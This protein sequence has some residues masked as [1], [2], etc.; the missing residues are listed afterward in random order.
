MRYFL[1]K[2]KTIDKNNDEKTFETNAL[3]LGN[4][5]FDIF[6]QV[7]NNSCYV[8][9]DQA[10]NLHIDYTNYLRQKAYTLVS[11][12][13]KELLSREY[14]ALKLSCIY[15]V[16]N[17]P[18]EHIINDTDL[19]QA[20]CTIQALSNDLAEFYNYRPATN[21]VYNSYYSIFKNNIGHK[22]TKVELINEFRRF[23]AGREKIRKNF[24]E[25]IEILKE[26]ATDDGHILDCKPI[27]NNSGN[28]YVLYKK[29][30]EILSSNV[31]SLEKL[32]TPVNAV[33]VVNPL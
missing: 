10:N 25:I 11:L 23:G 12:L 31:S 3:T 14:K 20:I 29:P 24:D 13:E 18:K 32:I 15:A 16:L 7:N 27:N 8:L 2:L 30:D 5:L 17:H 1:F 19:A 4:K 33:N 6:I 22:Y 9:S 28:E 21:D 26:I